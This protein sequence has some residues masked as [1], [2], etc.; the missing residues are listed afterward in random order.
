MKGNLAMPE[1]YW[2]IWN[3]ER[4]LPKFR[5]PS[6]EF[7]KVEAKRLALLHPGQEFHVLESQGFMKAS[8]PCQWITPKATQPRPWGPGTPCPACHQIKDHN[9]DCQCP[10]F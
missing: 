1:K 7:A 5:H 2:I 4:G 10:P 3:P 9:G 8:E 6:F